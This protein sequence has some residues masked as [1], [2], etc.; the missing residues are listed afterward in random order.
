MHPSFCNAVMDAFKYLHIRTQDLSFDTV[1]KLVFAQTA[2]GSPMRLLLANMYAYTLNEDAD[3]EL[4]DVLE[5]FP[6]S[7]LIDVVAAMVHMRKVD[8]E[9]WWTHF[10]GA[11]YH[12]V[13]AEEVVE[14]DVEVRVFNRYWRWTS[15]RSINSSRAEP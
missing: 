1:I 5:F 7:F 8:G 13:E 4:V 11:A 15:T 2:I 6:K 12:Y 14:V 3:A 10:E 9:G